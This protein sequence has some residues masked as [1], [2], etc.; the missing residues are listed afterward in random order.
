MTVRLVDVDVAMR[1]HAFDWE[2]HHMI[3]MREGQRKRE[4]EKKEGRGE[5]EGERKG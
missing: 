4:S 1:R 5:G 3:G 2:G